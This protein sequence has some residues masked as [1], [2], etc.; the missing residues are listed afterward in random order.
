MAKYLTRTERCAV[1]GRESE[2]RVLLSRY[3]ADRELDRKPLGDVVS[4]ALECPHCR[5]AA[6]DLEEPVSAA[7]RAYVLCEDYQ[8]W[9]RRQEDAMLRRLEGA[10]KI[11]EHLEQWAEAADCW[12]SAAWYCEEH[13]MEARAEENRALAVQMVETVPGLHLTPEQLLSYIDSLR[14]LGHFARA[15]Q[16]SRQMEDGF[17]RALGEHALLTKLLRREITL[18]QGGD[19]AAHRVSEVE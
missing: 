12:L 18:A 3:V 13:G 2:Q 5:Y 6:N 10:A 8:A 19:R 14:R 17:V 4:F 1:C 7:K 9:T 16:L 11:A 15:E